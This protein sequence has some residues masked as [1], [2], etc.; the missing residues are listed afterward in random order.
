ML[1]GSRPS[2]P[3]ASSP[4][5]SNSFIHHFRICPMREAIDL[6]QS[7][8]QSNSSLSRLLSQSTLSLRSCHVSYHW[9]AHACTYSSDC[10]PIFPMG[11]AQLTPFAL[12]NWPLYGQL[13]SSFIC[14][15]SNN[16]FTIHGIV[17]FALP[18]TGCAFAAVTGVLPH[19]N[20]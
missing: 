20:T 2:S 13:L 6:K 18:T 11:N 4:S 3:T 15:L 10:A 17:H 1:S 12:P 7:S 8:Y 16:S 14:Q 19:A 5:P 9:T